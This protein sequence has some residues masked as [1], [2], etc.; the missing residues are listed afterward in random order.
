MKIA[1]RLAVATLLAMLI[2]PTVTSVAYADSRHCDA[3][4]QD[5]DDCKREKPKFQ[6]KF[7]PN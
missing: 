5:D 4:Q 1:S 6:T 3:Q 2:A 7:F